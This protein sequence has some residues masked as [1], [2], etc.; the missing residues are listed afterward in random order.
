[1]PITQFLED[2]ARKYA[3]EVALVELNPEIKEVR[4]TTWKEYEL[5]ERPVGRAYRREITWRV[6]DEKANRC[7]NLLISRGVKKG[8]KVAILMM[9][10]IEWLPIY[11]GALK[12][13]ALAVPLNF[14]YTAEEIRYCLDLADADVLMFGP[15]FIGRLEEIYDDLKCQMI[16]CGPGMTPSFAEITRS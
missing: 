1:M 3:N 8:D 10:G 16:Y 4:R 6:M 13:G 15:E 7:A 12:A 11:F 14:R 2:N 5:I 9:N